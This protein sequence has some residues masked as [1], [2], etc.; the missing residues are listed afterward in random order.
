METP[1]KFEEQWREAFEGAEASPNPAVWD[2]VELAVANSANGSFKRR[3]LFFKLMAAASI[4]FAFTVVGIGIYRELYVTEDSVTLAD[5]NK[6]STTIP[7]VKDLDKASNEGN[8]PQERIAKSN[9]SVEGK[10][11]DVEGSESDAASKSSKSG[12]VPFDNSVSATRDGI[13]PQSI[14]DAN[15][16][17]ESLINEKLNTSTAADTEGGSFTG[18]PLALSEADEGVTTPSAGY[19][20]KDKTLAS[21]PKKLQ[22]RMIELE[23]FTFSDPEL[24]MVPW[25]SAVSQNKRTHE[26]GK[27]WAGLGMDGGSFNPSGGIS[28][29]SSDEAS[30][31]LS[32]DNFSQSGQSP[33]LGRE[34]NGRSINIGLNF[35][36]RI[37]PRWIIQSGLVLMDRSTTNSSNI[38][39][40]TGNSLRAINA[41]NEL[42]NTADLNVIDTYEIDNSYRFISVPIQAG[43][44]ILDRK[45][46]I[47]LLGGVSNDLFLSK[48]V[49]GQASG[50]QEYNVEDGIR[51]YNLTGLMGTELG[52][53][54]GQHYLFAITP[55]IR[56]SISTT[57]ISGEDVRP[58]FF[59]LGF[60]FKYLLK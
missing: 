3:I 44:L 56:Q 48:K 47:T 18:L 52:Y 16:A 1:N 34:E 43:Y 23:A 26:S 40:N 29:S 19:S 2:K 25:Y 45:F 35:G 33:I 27:F 10:E 17:D 24:S 49:D 28:A 32:A 36:A 38:A 15:L 58:T 13:L 7:S 4:V 8:D 42:S 59:E 50:F 41:L 21:I 55:Q 14:A 54:F 20:R 37:A 60:R 9:I 31:S 57:T 46:A 11:G 22:R 6:D 53:K 39:Q 12:V 5:D 51:R 30:F